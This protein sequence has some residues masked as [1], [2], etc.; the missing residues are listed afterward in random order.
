MNPR[1]SIIIPAYNEARLLPRLIESIKIA[2]IRFDREQVEI[3]VADNLSTDETRTIAESMECNVVTVTKRRIAAARNGGAKAANGEIFCFIDADSQLHPET[4]LK[5]QEA[6]SNERSIA[7]A[8][9]VFLERRSIGLMA[10]YLMMLPLIWITGMDTGVV[11]CRREDFDA[12]GGYNEDLFVAED[13]TFLYALKRL[14][15]TRGQRL[16]RLS[17]VRALGS[18]RKFDELGDWHYFFMIP[19]VIMLLAQKGLRSFVKQDDVPDLTNYWY[20]P[21][22]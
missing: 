13:V 1:F 15:K 2:A 17:G 5:I 12:I 11:F 8:T 10:T 3:I 18:T 19:K 14:G 21:Q 16:T 6:M 20:R 4:F 7:G 9:G 22:R